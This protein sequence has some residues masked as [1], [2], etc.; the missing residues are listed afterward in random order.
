MRDAAF[1]VLQLLYFMAPAYVANMVPPF[2]RFWPGW[3]RPIHARLLG[4]HKTVLGFAVGVL[5]GILATALQATLATA[6][7]LV[8]YRDWPLLGFEFGFG[9]MAG[10]SVKSLLKRKAGIAP[11]ARWFPLDQLDFVIGA[12]LL[13]GFRAGLTWQDIAI[14]L[15]VTLIGALPVNRLAFRLR[16]KQTP[17]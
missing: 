9:A 6:L 16:I 14:I 15:A 8:D 13:V 12:L 5:A 3:N 2:V 17:W 10:D 7:D 1:H 11:G 4:E